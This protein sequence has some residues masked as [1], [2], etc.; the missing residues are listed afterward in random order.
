MGLLNCCRQWG[1]TMTI[2]E[3]REA[4]RDNDNRRRR[5]RYAWCRSLGLDSV[6]S[7]TMQK[8]SRGRVER[9]LFDA[10]EDERITTFTRIWARSFYHLNAAELNDRYREQSAR[11]AA[12]PRGRAMKAANEDRMRGQYPERFKARQMLRNAVAAG[13]IVRG[14][15]E[16]CGGTNTEGHHDDYNKPLTARWFCHQHHCELEGRWLPRN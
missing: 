1:D 14:P 11:Y 9:L 5:E 6:L 7:R 13:S 3:Q 2:Q 8:W 16:V 15:C 12:S 10:T 4:I